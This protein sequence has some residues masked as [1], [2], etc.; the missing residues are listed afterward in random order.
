MSGYPTACPSLDERVV[1]ESTV[2]RGETSPE[3]TVA[4]TALGGLQKCGP[5]DPCGR[6]LGQDGAALSGGKSGRVFKPAKPARSRLDFA[7]QESIGV[8]DGAGLSGAGFLENP[9]GHSADAGSRW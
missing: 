4:T 5:K 8:W 7:R 9:A 1:G 6:V 2:S 3:R